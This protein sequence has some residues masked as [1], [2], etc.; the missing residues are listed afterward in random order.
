MLTAHH[1]IIG[2]LLVTIHLIPNE[3]WMFANKQV[4][5]F[6]KSL[7]VLSLKWILADK[8]GAKFTM[9]TFMKLI[10]RSFIWYVTQAKRSV[11]MTRVMDVEL[12]GF[13]CVFLLIDKALLHALPVSTF[14]LLL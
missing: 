12:M 6:V 5:L 14:E 2:P 10:E 11:S 7:R 4:L 9:L 13:L 8:M 1:S 3:G